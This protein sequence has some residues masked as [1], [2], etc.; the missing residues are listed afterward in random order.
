[1][2][3]VDDNLEEG[4]EEKATRML[5]DMLGDTRIL[6]SSFSDK[7]RKVLPPDHLQYTWS[8]N[9]V[10]DLA[11]NTPDEFDVLSVTDDRVLDARINVIRCDELVFQSTGNLILNGGIVDPAI[12]TSTDT[13]VIA[14]KRLLLRSPI[15]SAV[16]SVSPNK[17]PA[18]VRNAAQ[19]G[20]NGRSGG[21]PGGHGLRGANGQNGSFQGRDASKNIFLIFNDI[22]ITIPSDPTAAYPPLRVEADG[23]SGI[24][25]QKGGKGGNGGNGGKGKTSWGDWLQCVRGPGRGGNGGAAG[26]GGSGSDGQI[27]N[28]GHNVYLLSTQPAV[29]KMIG[30]GFTLRGGPSGVGGRGGAPGRPGNG[31]PEGNLVGSCRRAGRHGAPGTSGSFGAN[32]RSTHAG[33][34]GKIYIEPIS[35]AEFE[36]IWT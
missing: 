3:S 21:E 31:G 10:L 4:F 35:L 30:F 2:S 25:G 17:D 32:G 18:G 20:R 6:T 8:K 19:R 36:G 14:A 7:P 28:Q 29:E 34:N 33:P 12:G 24:K 15:D 11:R 22:E 23:L 1:M 27:G 9:E 5:G 26:N 13:V 16:I